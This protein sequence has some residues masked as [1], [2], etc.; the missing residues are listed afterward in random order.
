VAS[1]SWVQRCSHRSPVW[2][3]Q[4]ALLR[5]ILHL[6]SCFSAFLCSALISQ[7]PVHFGT[8]PPLT[9]SPAAPMASTSA[10][11]AHRRSTEEPRPIL[12][13]LTRY[14]YF[15]H[16]KSS[17]CRVDGCQLQWCCQVPC[18][19]EFSRPGG[20][21]LKPSPSAVLTCRAGTAKTIRARATQL[22][23]NSMSVRGV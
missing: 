21:G 15:D 8:K 1:G 13:L 17:C 16:D 4:H 12:D 10:T 11:A 19:A 23:T 22:L 2:S 14:Q 9:R 6:T 20:Q 7:R 5:S 18:R 3:V